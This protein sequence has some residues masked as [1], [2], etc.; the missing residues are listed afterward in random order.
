MKYSKT[1]HYKYKLEETE[2]RQ[3]EITGF[4]FNN[5]YMAMLEN[6][7]IFSKAGYAWDG[8]SIPYKKFLRI[9]TMGIYDPDKYCKTASLIHDTFYQAIRE[10]LLSKHEKIKADILY[11]QMCIEGG[12]SEGWATGRYKALRKFGD[13]GIVPEKNPRNRVYDTEDGG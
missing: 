1:R 5:R 6:G 11:R 13:R 3:T 7:Q 12:M 9:L 8:S 2:M 4:S 10:G